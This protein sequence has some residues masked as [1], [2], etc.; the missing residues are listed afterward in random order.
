M[1]SIDKKQMLNDILNEE[2][3]IHQVLTQE[4]FLIKTF[5]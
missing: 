2:M 4:L 1:D 3:L 5:S